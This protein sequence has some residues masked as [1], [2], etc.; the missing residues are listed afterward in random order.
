MFSFKNMGFL[1]TLDT[2]GRTIGTA[3]ATCSKNFL[4]LFLC[5]IIQRSIVHACTIA[6][7]IVCTHT[8][9]LFKPLLILGI[10]GVFVFYIPLRLVN[11]YGILPFY[12]FCFR[13]EMF[14][15]NM[16]RVMLT[17]FRR[18]ARL[19]PPVVATNHRLVQRKLCNRLRDITF[20]AQLLGQYFI[21]R[22]RTELHCFIAVLTT[23]LYATFAVTPFGESIEGFDLGTQRAL[24]HRHLHSGISRSVGLPM[25]W[26]RDLRG[27]AAYPTPHKYSSNKA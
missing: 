13:S 20:R 6:L 8:W 7:N 16:V 1:S 19:T 2:I 3:M 21:G 10:F 22:I 18:M 11:L 9:M 26:H 24:F 12:A 5:Q 25:L 27:C 23:R 14:C 4:K 15:F 17:L